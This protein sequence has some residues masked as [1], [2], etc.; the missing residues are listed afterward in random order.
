MRVSHL[1]HASVSQVVV[2]SLFSL[3]HVLMLSVR[4][5]W[6]PHRVLSFFFN[7]TKLNTSF[8]TISLKPPETS[9]PGS[10]FP[11]AD[12]LITLSSNCFALCHTFEAPRV[13][14]LLVYFA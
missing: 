13:A 10:G 1:L 2:C 6:C 5:S 12:A 7:A 4:S 9:V 3:F 14:C 11:L 8:H